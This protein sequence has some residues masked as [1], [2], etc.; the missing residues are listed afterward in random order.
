MNWTNNFSSN[1]FVYVNQVGLPISVMNDTSYLSANYTQDNSMKTKCQSFPQGHRFAVYNLNASSYNNTISTSVGNNIT[2]QLQDNYNLDCKP[3]RY[4]TNNYVI[5]ENETEKVSLAVYVDIPISNLNNPQLQTEYIANFDGIY[6]RLYHSYYFNTSLIENANTVNVNLTSANDV[7]V[8]LLDSNGNIKAKSINNT[9][10][11]LTYTGLLQNQFWEIRVSGNQTS[12]YVGSIM[13]NG[14]NYSNS[15]D[16]G[17][18]NATQNQTKTVS[19]KNLWQNQETIVSYSP[20]I[21][22]TTKF[23]DNKP[24]NFTFI[25]ANSSVVSTLQ[26]SVESNA[27]FVINLYKDDQLVTSSSK[28]QNIAKNASMPVEEYVITT[29]ILPGVWRM[30]IINYTAF[31]S[32]NATV[33]QYFQNMISANVTTFSLSQNEEAVIEST[34]TI[35]TNVIDGKYEGYIDFYNS[36]RSFVRVPI[37][38]NVTTPVLVVN[39]S[40]TMNQHSK[41]HNYGQNTSMNVVFQLNNTGS[42]PVNISISSSNLT[43]QANYIFV[44]H[45]SS[46]QIQPF[47]SVNIPVDISFNSSAPTGTYQGWIYFDSLG[48]EEQKSHPKQNYNISLSMQ[49]TDQLIINISEIKTHDG[50][51]YIRDNSNDQHVLMRL[52][53]FYINGTEIEAGNALNLSN[54]E[55]WLEHANISYR[56]PLSGN[57]TTYNGTIPLYYSNYYSI[58]FTVPANKLGGLYKSYARLAWNRDNKTYTGISYNTSLV[59][60]DTALVMTTLNSTSL[61]LQTSK[62][63]VYAINVTN[64][65]EKAKNSYTLIMNES[66]SGYEIITKE[67]IGCS[68]SRTDYNFTY[69]PDAGSSCVFAWKITTGSN[70]ATS[71]TAY[72]R[73]T[74]QNGWLDPSA[75][76]VSIRVETPSQAQ[77]TT[78]TVATEEPQLEEIREEEINYF[79]VSYPSTFSVEQ[80]KNKSMEVRITNSYSKTQT[81]KLSLSS[82]NSSWF[83]VSPNEKA[84]TSKNSYTYR[85]IFTIPE[86][87]EIKDYNGQINVE[88]TYKTEKLKFT[89]KVTPGDNLKSLIESTVEAYE[90]KLEELKK[91]YNSTNETVR[92]QIDEIENAVKE[93]RGYIDIGDYASAYAILYDVK[94]MIDQVEIPENNVKASAAFNWPITLIASSGVL[95]LSALGYTAFETFKKKGWL[96]VKHKKTKSGKSELN[97][98]KESLKLRELEEEIKTVEQREKELEEEIKRIK[99]KEK[100]LESKSPQT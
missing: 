22:H 20:V 33:Y 29:N 70:N 24:R 73:A 3:G 68:A 14:L 76:N 56:I 96:K 46:V 74:P 36:R 27:S 92:V 100:E 21:Y 77:V 34:L 65:G 51:V 38:F 1:L 89:L 60:N 99:E 35:P 15:L 13:F 81:I 17:V 19:L 18:L 95:F 11:I 40:F 4:Y 72:I 48:N 57:L 50:S 64:F 85:I 26:V 52:K 67:S 88:S 84:I 91:A 90:L 10:E 41:T 32:Y 83:I 82:I 79:S 61:T 54:F 12:S 49:L 71:C 23:S 47:S 80:G 45:I 98:I 30:E 6:D 28:K 31:S 93:L 42:L 97:E 59:I 8:F 7:D 94:K 87:A 5:G 66:C 75:V 43:N 78:T 62:D 44:S 16:F 58:N 63:Y 69:T 2:V 39:S 25:V 9:R 55:L 53:A 86:D 37:S